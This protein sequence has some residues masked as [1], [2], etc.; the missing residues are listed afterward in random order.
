[1]P[2]RQDLWQLVNSF[3]LSQALYVAGTLGLA[4]L[5][6]DGARSSDDLARDTDTNPD[7][8]YRL[9]RALASVGVFHEHENRDFSLTELGQDLRTDSPST[10][11]GW[12]AFVGRP[13]IWHAWGDLLHSVRTG[14][15]A[16][17][18]VHGTDVWS[19]RNDHPEDGRIFDRAMSDLTV[20]IHQAILDAY[21]FGRLDTVVDVAGGRGALL[22]SLLD[23]YPQMNGVLFDQPA[24][25]ADALQHDRLRVESGS[26]FESVPE[27]GDAYMLKW[28]IHDWE[29]PECLAILRTCRTAM[30]GDATLLLLERIVGA[31]NTDPA[32]KF[33]DL[34][35]LV[36]P[37]GRERTVD[38]F[39]TLLAE[40]GFELQ[41]VSGGDPIAV[42]EAR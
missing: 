27:G 38:E 29:D 14:E 10:I 12:A 15:N 3:R 11:A 40:A 34:N 37:G 22:V 21:D 35:M 30:S 23:A 1:L 33:S 42:L 8:L 20:H 36:M 25:V 13:H 31:P 5:V 39:S 17:K 41:N 28:I 24:V 18:H 19:F 4:D 32:A 26:F 16:F 6:G 9:L 7:A 2:P